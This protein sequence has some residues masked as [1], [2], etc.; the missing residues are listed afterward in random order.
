MFKQRLRHEPRS[1]VQAFTHYPSDPTD[2]RPYS[3]RADVQ[4]ISP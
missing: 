4:P 2:V 3:E 1:R